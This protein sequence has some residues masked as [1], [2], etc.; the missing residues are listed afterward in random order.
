[1]LRVH[2][3]PGVLSV[4]NDFTLRALPASFT[5]NMSMWIPIQK[6]RTGVTIFPIYRYLTKVGAVY[7][8]TWA[9]FII[10]GAV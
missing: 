3:S 6:Y 8:V 9:Q 2:C 7:K 1:M 10:V 4:A 5:V